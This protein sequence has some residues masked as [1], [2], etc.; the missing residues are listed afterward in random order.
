MNINSERLDT[1]SE[2]ALN[3][4]K[5]QI[6]PDYMKRRWLRAL[7]KAKERLIERPLFAWQP[8][9]LILVSVPEKN[10]SE[11]G[12]RFYEASAQTCRRIDK[13]GLCQAFF[14]GYPCWHRAAHLLLEVYFNERAEAQSDKDQNQTA[15]AKVSTETV[16]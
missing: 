12:C 10:S 3:A 2:I 9:A 4:V 13:S 8:S 11:I 5:N 7:E 6:L 14:E 1:A 15:V 16:N